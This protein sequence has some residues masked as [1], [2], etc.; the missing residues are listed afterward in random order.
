MINKFLNAEI[1]QTFIIKTLG[2]LLFLF[3]IF[4]EF[5]SLDK[6]ASL[7]YFFIG[8]ISSLI[9]FFSSSKISL[10]SPF[11]NFFTSL[12]FAII[13]SAF[14]YFANNVDIMH[15]PMLRS[16]TLIDEINILYLLFFISMI[17]PI[18]FSLFCNV[19]L[20]KFRIPRLNERLLYYIILY[21]IILL[22]VFLS[23][24]FILS[25]TTPIS[26]LINPMSFR[27]GLTGSALF[28]H[29]IFSLILNF[30]LII[31]FWDTLKNKNT[32]HIKY[33]LML[34]GL[35]LFYTLI[36]GRRGV[37]VFAVFYL[38]MIFSF[39]KKIRV[40]HLFGALVLLIALLGFSSIYL[41]YRNTAAALAY[42]NYEAAYKKSNTSVN[43]FADFAERNDSFVN[44][45]N[46]FKYI[47]R[48][49][50]D[51]SIIIDNPM[52]LKEELLYHTLSYLPREQKNKI[53]GGNSKGRLFCNVMSDN[54]Y[55]NSSSYYQVGFDFGGIAN[56]YWVFGV[57]GII[58]SGFLYG[59]FVSILQL[60][61]NKYKQNECFIAFYLLIFYS[62]IDVFFKTGYINCPTII[63]L[64]FNLI[65]LGIIMLPCVYKIKIK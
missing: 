21:Y 35:L 32:I 18:A 30:L 24:L 52:H 1:K 14:Y 51:S 33:K 42:G 46:F 54:I 29:L 55:D 26:A 47:N 49:Y 5:I 22:V 27:N 64:P 44:S 31:V 12:F 45:I 36:S 48:Y 3:C 2:V 23:F 10:F 9:I 34:L 63:N 11:Y 8:I 62:V 25:G 59:I 13:F 28:P 41:K 37:L 39:V 56:F 15:K 50:S 43:L 6:L 57:L 40:K 61:F 20:P 16:G 65:V 53:Y 7:P 19:R 17:I 4:G 38:I 60:L 58:I